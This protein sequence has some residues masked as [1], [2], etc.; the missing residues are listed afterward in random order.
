MNG[1]IVDVFL[2]PLY[3]FLSLFHLLLRTPAGACVVISTRSLALPVGCTVHNWWV[4][5]TAISQLPRPPFC[6]CWCWSSKIRPVFFCSL[7]FTFKR[8][9]NDVWRM[10]LVTNTKLFHE[11]WH[12]R[13][14]AGFFSCIFLVIILKLKLL[15]KL[16]R[17]VHYLHVLF[18]EMVKL[19]RKISTMFWKLT[20]YSVTVAY[21][22]NIY[23]YFHMVFLS[24]S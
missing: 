23:M 1:V 8:I 16:C 19:Q 14:R 11:E 12:W 4:A 13:E 6:E 2:W 9:R 22:F 5:C 20:N 7:V 17:Y 15:Y 21:I 3:F 18:K 24:A 10:Y